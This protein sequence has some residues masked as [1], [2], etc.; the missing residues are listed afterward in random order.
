[1]KFFALNAFAVLTMVKNVEINKLTY[2]QQITYDSEYLIF[3][4]TFLNVSI[5]VKH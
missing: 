5:F 4:S 3:I 2:C 1:M